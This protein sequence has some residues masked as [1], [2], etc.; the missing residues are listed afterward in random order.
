MPL[1]VFT[2][3][4]TISHMTYFPNHS[5]AQRLLQTFAPP[6]KQYGCKRELMSQMV[7]S[8][9]ASFI[10]FTFKSNVSLF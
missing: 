7:L 6:L 9:V 5:E 3:D 4:V 8:V 1:E 2:A 10:K